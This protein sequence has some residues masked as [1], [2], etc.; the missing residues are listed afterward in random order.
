MA[1]QYPPRRS[2]EQLHSI[3][4]ET[5]I[6]A[7]NGRNG[8]VLCAAPS[9]HCALERATQYAAS[10]AVVVAICRSQ[11]DNIIVFEEQANRLRKLCA[12]SE[13]PPMYGAQY[14]E[15]LIGHV[16]RETTPRIRRG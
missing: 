2:D 16:T 3:L 9:L 12:N 6:W 4:F 10:G 8:Q 15:D 14:W 1:S 7:I 13:V 5:A 11:G